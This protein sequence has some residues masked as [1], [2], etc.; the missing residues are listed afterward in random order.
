MQDNF[1]TTI[2]VAQSAAQVFNAINNPRAWWSEE[3]QGDTAQLGSRWYYH[4]QDVHRCTLEVTQL[5][6][7]QKVAWTVIDNHFSFTHDKNEWKANRLVFEISEKDGQTQ[8]TFTQ[9][10]LVP[11]YECYDICQKAWQTYIDESLFS[12]IT[13]GKGNPNSTG[14]PTTEDEKAL[15]QPGFTTTF[16]VD[17]SPAE[18]YAAV[19]NVRSWWH[20]EVS[21]P[22][23]AVGDEFSYRMKD[24]HYSR[25]RVT[26]LVPNQ[27]VTWLVTDSKLKGYANPSEW[28]GTTI[29]FEITP[30]NK[31]TQLRFTHHGLVKEFECFGGCSWGWEELVQKSLLGLVVSGKGVEVFKDVG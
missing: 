1:T 17:Q 23:L 5:V 22:T 19:N 27:K 4:Y 24:V 10:G 3:I 7:H 25:Q 14:N 18:V 12:L 20:G 29:T 15:S 16:F 21:G 31:K 28:T 6:P 30:I 2:T 13:T 26:G 9:I 8:L 11:T